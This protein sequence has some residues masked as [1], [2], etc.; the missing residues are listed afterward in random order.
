MRRWRGSGTQWGRRARQSWCGCEQSWKRPRRWEGRLSWRAI[1]HAICMAGWQACSAHSA[2]V[3]QRP[4]ADRASA[5]LASAAGGRRPAAQAAF[6]RQKMER[7]EVAVQK[8]AEERRAAEVGLRRQGASWKRTMARE[9]C[10]SRSAA[11]M[12]ASLVCTHHLAV[13]LSGVTLPCPQILCG[14]TPPPCFPQAARRAEEERRE[15]ARRE[16]LARAEAEQAERARWLQARSRHKETQLEARSRELAELRALHQRQ[17]QMRAEYARWAQTDCLLCPQL[18][19][20]LR[21]PSRCRAKARRFCRKGLCLG[22]N[23]QQQ[24]TLKQHPRLLRRILPAALPSWPPCLPCPQ[25]PPGAGCAARGGA[26]AAAD[27]PAGGQAAPRGSDG[28]GEGG[29]AAGPGGGPAGDPAPGGR[30]Q[31][32]RAGVGLACRHRSGAAR[33]KPCGLSPGVS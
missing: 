12:A 25:A 16:A 15:A 29:D 5:G 26:A 28:G 22:A 19:D 33:C 32:R 17:R 10:P 27:Q 30:A 2:V 4:F 3:M 23:Q 13:P 6:M 20:H 14:C 8:A 1:V 31:V 9:C 21:V 18:P 11:R 7:H 24:I